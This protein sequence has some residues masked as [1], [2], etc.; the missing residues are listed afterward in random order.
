[1]TTKKII[2]ATFGG[3]SEALQ[4]SKFKLELKNVTINNNTGLIELEVEGNNLDELQDF[5]Y[6]DLKYRYQEIDTGEIIPVLK[7][8]RTKPF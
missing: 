7:E 1:M 6:L 5:P 8:F 2:K 3:L 4:F